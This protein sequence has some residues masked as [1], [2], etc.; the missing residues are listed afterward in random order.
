MSQLPCWQ[1]D[2]RCRG[3][4]L[5]WWAAE[6]EK[7]HT[8]FRSRGGSLR[9]LITS[10]EAEGTTETFACRFCTVSLTVTRRPFQSFFVSLAISSPTFLGER[11]SGP[12]FGAREEA[13]P[14]SPPV[15]RRKTSMTE[16]G[17]NLGGILQGQHVYAALL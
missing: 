8:F 17:S 4:K 7:Q 9:A 5:W 12:I 14:T 13:A 1:Y 6:G 11:P 15:A 16:E 2:D 10:A 3:R